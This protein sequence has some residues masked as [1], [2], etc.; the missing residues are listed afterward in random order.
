MFFG[1]CFLFFFLGPRLWYMEVS[2]LGV[3]SELQL[4][5]YAIATVTSDTQPTEQG[6]GIEPAWT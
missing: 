1:F 3:E 4:P 6:P 5:A 2:R